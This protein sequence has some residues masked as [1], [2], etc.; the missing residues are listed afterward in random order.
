MRVSMTNMTKEQRVILAN[1]FISLIAST[2]RRFFHCRHDDGTDQIARFTI[3]DSGHIF[4]WNEYKL[5]WIYVSRYGA[6]K[7]FH[8]GGTLHG[9]VGAIVDWIKTGEAR[10]HPTY[11]TAKHWAYS[12]KDIDAI[13][14]LGQNIGLIKKDES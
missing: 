7:G 10:L 9:L 3:R 11:I 13:I 5:H 12:Q 2:G 14:W 8:H 4:F 6:W 1:G